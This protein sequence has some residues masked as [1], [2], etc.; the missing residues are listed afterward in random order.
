MNILKE[1]AKAVSEITG[2]LVDMN[3]SFNPA[4]PFL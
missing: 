3:R 1:S 2:L 4:A